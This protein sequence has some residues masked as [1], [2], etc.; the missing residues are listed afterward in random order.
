MLAAFVALVVD[1]SERGSVFAVFAFKIINGKDGIS[2][3]VMDLC[4]P[5]AVYRENR[6]LPCVFIFK[7]DGK[8]LFYAVDSENIFYSL[9]AFFRLKTREQWERMKYP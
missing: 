3:R 2:C 6:M 5:V 7:A 1:G 9:K 8:R 4:N